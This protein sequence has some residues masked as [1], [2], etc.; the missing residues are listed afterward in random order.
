MCY[1]IFTYRIQPGWKLRCSF[2]CID[3]WLFIMCPTVF[4]FTSNHPQ[5]IQPTATRS[6]LDGSCL[7]SSCPAPHLAENPHQLKLEQDPG[8]KKDGG[9]DGV[10]QCKPEL[11][12]EVFKN[13]FQNLKPKIRIELA[14]TRSASDVIESVISVLL[15][16]SRKT[17]EARF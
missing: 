11:K 17:F 14:T 9:N 7:I 8:W 2:F 16:Y 1:R 5:L 13:F 15:K 6:V 4:S 10:L 3:G 12:K